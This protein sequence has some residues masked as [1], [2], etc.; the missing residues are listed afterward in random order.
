MS[1]FSFYRFSYLIEHCGE[2]LGVWKNKL[3]CASIKEYRFELYKLEN[4]GRQHGQQQQQ[5]IKMNSI[6][7][8]I[9]FLNRSTGFGFR[10]SD[11]PGFKEN[12]V[13]FISA[14]FRRSAVGPQEEFFDVCKYD[15]KTGRTEKL[16]SVES[17]LAYWFFPSLQ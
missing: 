2:L 12:C 3:W 14:R 5:W 7:D 6:G 17:I 15:I 9:L 13:Y 16:K 11:F 4:N 10:A 1:T 8:R